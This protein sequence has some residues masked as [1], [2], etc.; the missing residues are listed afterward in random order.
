MG[1]PGMQNP[2]FA[3]M[4]QRQMYQPSPS[5]HQFMQPGAQPGMQG[6]PQQPGQQ[7]QQGWQY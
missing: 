2:A 1:Y 6:W 5:P 4:Q 7:G 3:N